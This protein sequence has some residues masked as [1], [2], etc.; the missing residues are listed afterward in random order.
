[1]A[2]YGDMIPK[3]KSD[4]RLPAD[5]RTYATHGGIDGCGRDRESQYDIIAN[6]INLLLR[7]QNR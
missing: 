7:Y 1:V 6:H 5:G 2:D 3:A 4:N